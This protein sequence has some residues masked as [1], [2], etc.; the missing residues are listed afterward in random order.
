M[1]YIPGTMPGVKQRPKV[2]RRSSI[3]VQANPIP[4][5]NSSMAVDAGPIAEAIPAP[6]AQPA[7]KR[8]TAPAGKGKASGWPSWYPLAVGI[9]LG[10]L[11]PVLYSLVVLWAPWGPRIVFPL[12]QIVGL[13]EI[14]M[15]DELTRTL[16]Q[17]MLYLQFPLEG[18]LVASNMRRGKGIAMSIVPIPALHALCTL[19]L[20]IIAL[21]S[22]RPI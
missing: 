4:N 3:S 18:I 17:L 22:S 19:M 5:T 7:V 15:S 6:K 14:G 8:T 11:A 9:L 20:W 10:F 21:G 2:A 1:P 13:R 16:P 12:V